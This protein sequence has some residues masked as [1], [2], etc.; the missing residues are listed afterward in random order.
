MNIGRT[1]GQRE[2]RSLDRSSATA[3]TN[4]YEVQ[5]DLQ[6][7]MQDLVG[8]VRQEEEMEQA[9]ESIEELESAQRTRRR[10]AAIAN[11]IP[12]GTRRSIWTIC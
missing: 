11:T 5:H 1:R 6:D 10:R 12:A 9:L 2:A 3:A 4:P 7:M 8:I